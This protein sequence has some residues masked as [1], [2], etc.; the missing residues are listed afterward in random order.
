ME[1]LV[2][3]ERI[4]RIGLVIHPII[5]QDQDDE[6]EKEEDGDLLQGLCHHPSPLKLK[7]EKGM[8][9]ILSEKYEKEDKG[10]IDRPPD[11]DR[12]S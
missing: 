11:P 10:I 1:D 5:H 2:V 8:I 6:K 3:L 12:L 4:M 7:I 9:V